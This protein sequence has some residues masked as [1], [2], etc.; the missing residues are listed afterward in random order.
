MLKVLRKDKSFIWVLK[1]YFPLI[2]LPNQNKQDQKVQ[3]APPAKVNLEGD[4]SSVDKTEAI[5]ETAEAQALVEAA[6]ITVA[7]HSDVDRFDF[8]FFD[9]DYEVDSYL[10]NQ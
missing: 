2:G 5:S 4:R 6:S 3:E 10:D 7:N 9:Y 1:I 8:N